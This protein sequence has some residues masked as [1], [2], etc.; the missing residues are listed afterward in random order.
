LVVT[1]DGF[2]LGY[3]IFAGNRADVTTVGE[4]VEVMEGRYGKANRIWVM[5]RGMASEENFGFLMKEGRRYILRT[6]RG[7]FKR[8]EAE[9]LKTD[10][11]A[12]QPGLLSEAGGES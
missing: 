9:L 5:D 11:Q 12:V 2:P 10:W 6:Q 8:Y 4:I 3:E 1:R 7:Q